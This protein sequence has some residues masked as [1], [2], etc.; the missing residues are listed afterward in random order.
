MTIVCRDDKSWIGLYKHTSSNT[1]PDP[2][3]QYW[4]DNSTSSFRRWED[5]KPDTD[6]TTC[7]RMKESSGE[8]DD[9]DCASEYGFVCKRTAGQFCLSVMNISMKNLTT[10]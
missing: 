3:G 1:D 7:I 8:F 5:G 10:T 2:S 9:E 6:D 4:L